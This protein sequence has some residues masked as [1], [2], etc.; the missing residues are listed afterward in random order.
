MQVRASMTDK[1]L[2]KSS[3]LLRGAEFERVFAARASAG[4]KLM[5]VYG[6]ANDLDKP[7]LG[8]AVSRRHG[9][10]VVRNRWKRVIREAFRAVQQDLPALDL[11]CVPRA[12]AAPDFAQIIS[13]LPK[14]AH[15][16]CEKRERRQPTQPTETERKVT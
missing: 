12:G 7:R 13:E 15:R 10:A 11:V 9:S 5:I 1:R 8:L 16:L 3:R 6:A 14:L 4:G 2:R